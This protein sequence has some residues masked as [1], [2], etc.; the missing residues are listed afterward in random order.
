MN[1]KDVSKLRLDQL[2]KIDEFYLKAYKSSTLYKEWIK[3]THDSS[4]LKWDFKVEDDV[5][6]LNLRYKLFLGKLKHGGQ[7]PLNWWII[8]LMEWLN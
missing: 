7:I 8:F 1:W 3:R 5:L 6:L 2:H 4:I